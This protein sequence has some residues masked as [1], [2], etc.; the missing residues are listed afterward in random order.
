MRTLLEKIAHKLTRRPKLVAAIAAVL[1]LLSIAGSAATRINYDIL[2]YLPPDLDSSKGEKLLEE[3]FHMAATTMLI[4]EG[5]PAGYTDDLRAAIEEVPGVSG[6]LWVSSLTGI[7]FPVEMLPQEV[8]DTFFAGNS[9][10]MMVQYEMP[11]AS[12]QTMEAIRQ[13]RALCNEKCFLA[14]FSVLIKDTKDLVDQELPLYVALAVVLSLVVMG[15]AMESWVLPLAFLTCIGL[16]IL[17]NFGTNIFLGEISYITKAIA[18]VLQLGVTMDYSIFL[19]HRY[20]EERDRYEDKR[21]AMAVAVQA[22]FTSLSSSSLT[23]IAGLEVLLLGGA[24]ENTVVPLTDLPQIMVSKQIPSAQFPLIKGRIPSFSDAG[25]R[26]WFTVWVD[27]AY[28]LGLMEGVGNG[29]FAPGQTLTVAEVVK[30]AAFLESQA[31]GDDFHLQPITASPWYSSSVAYCVA[32]GIISSSEFSD[33]E[34]PITRAE[35]VHILSSTALG[36]R[37]PEVNSL[38]RVKA[39]IPDVKPG[40]YAA[41]SIYKFYSKGLLAGTD[42]DLTFNPNGQLTRAEAAEHVD[43]ATCIRCGRCVNVCPMH[44]TPVYMHM[45]AEKRMWDEAEGLNLMD[46]IECGSCNYIC[47]ARVPLVQSFRMA[48]FEIRTLAMKRKAAAEKEAK[49]A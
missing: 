38:S 47:P 43:N 11:G 40:D 39:A 22:A 33:Y 37:L 25:P 7:Q 27:L 26:D 10:M 13:V 12:E 9:T 1:L 35:M 31:N 46:C 36:R 28:N 24:G 30:M 8:R 17:Y 49:K 4:V 21:D 23:T 6:A 16:A 5:M 44:L 14:G 19:Y 3:P 34:R 41:E 32:T 2:T 29:R 15:V 18:A 20:E 45:Y 48:K 42:T